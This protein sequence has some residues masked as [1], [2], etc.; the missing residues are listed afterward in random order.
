MDLSI[1]ATREVFLT[2]ISLFLIMSAIL[3]QLTNQATAYLDFCQENGWQTAAKVSVGGTSY[4]G[5]ACATQNKESVDYRHFACTNAYIFFYSN[6]HFTEDQNRSVQNTKGP[7]DLN[8]IPSNGFTS[9]EGTAGQ[10]GQSQGIPLDSGPPLLSK[11][12]EVIQID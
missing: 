12:K 4:K 10:P 1:L 6:C 11:K 3:F 2:L 9:S 7:I 5:L 8:L